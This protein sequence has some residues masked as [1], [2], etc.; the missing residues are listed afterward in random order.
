MTISLIACQSRNGVIG[1]DGRLPFN[2]PSDMKRF[3][4]LTLGKPCIM[5]RSTHD[6][7]L[8]PLE[9]RIN[10]VLSRYGYLEC[11]DGFVYFDG[12]YKAIEFAKQLPH[13]S[14]IMIIGGGQVYRQCL[15]IADKIYL[16]TLDIDLVGD[17]YF[18]KLDMGQWI[19]AS[20]ERCEDV[21]P[22]TYQVL[23]RRIE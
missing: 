18:P 20:K 23:D 5:G 6:G 4:K 10:I 22:Y 19:E 14:E 16:T 13:A 9:S 12:I 1:K 8:K 2:V 3:R 11:R 15:P 17:V 7:F 21:I